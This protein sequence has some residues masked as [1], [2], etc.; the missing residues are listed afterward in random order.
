MLQQKYWRILEKKIK[1]AVFI[2]YLL[3]KSFI[4]SLLSV[5]PNAQ[6]LSLNTTAI[7]FLLLS[8]YKNTKMLKANEKFE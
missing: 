7:W 3:N 8:L 1:N 2:N 4:A 6:I 5:S